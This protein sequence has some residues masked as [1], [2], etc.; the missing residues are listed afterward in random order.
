MPRPWRRSSAE[1]EILNHNT[2]TV[3]R[4]QR[5]VRTSASYGRSLALLARA[6]AAGRIVK[7]GLI[8]GMGETRDE[9]LAPWPT[10]G[11]WESTSSPSANTCGRPPGIVRSIATSTPTSSTST[12]TLG[13]ESA[14][15][16]SSR[17]RWFD[18]ATTPKTQPNPSPVAHC[19]ECPQW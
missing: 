6:K 1:P 3:L 17:V 19:L 4:L 12:D 11:R 5:D 8:V 13:A 16:T 15:P 7:S 18:R 14:Y 10:C 2:E 9:V